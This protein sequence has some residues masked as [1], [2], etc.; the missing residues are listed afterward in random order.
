MYL[1]DYQTLA[2]RTAKMYPVKAQNLI[3]AALGLSTEFMETICAIE[4][5]HVKEE[6]GDYCWYIPLACEALGLRLGQVVAEH[7][8][9]GEECATAAYVEAQNT[10]ILFLRHFGAEPTGNF[11]TMVKRVAIYDKPLTDE[12]ISQAKAQIVGMLQYAAM[13]CLVNG[14][15]LASCLREN[16]DKLKLRFPDKFSNEAAEARADKGGLDATQS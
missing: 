8:G 2:L 4:P 9:V 15:T 7:Y 1:N 12:M 13:V 10:A 6:I 3:H 5:K 16:I 11:I 14:F